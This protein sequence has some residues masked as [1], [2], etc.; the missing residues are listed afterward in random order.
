MIDCPDYKTWAARRATDAME[1]ELV[2]FVDDDDTVHPHAFKLCLRAMEESGLAAACTDELE[3]DINGRVLSRA[4]GEKTYFTAAVHPRVVHHVCVM[5]GTMIDPRA[6]EFHARFG[7]GVD[8]FIRSS[9]IMP[10]GCVHVPMFGHYWTQHAGQHTAQIRT[11][12]ATHVRDMGRLIRE[13]WP[14]RFEGKLP[15]LKL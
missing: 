5:R 11:L 1:H 7:V 13:T 14:A 2:A 15:V 8:W 10:G 12:F 4:F 6:A 9:V 3:V